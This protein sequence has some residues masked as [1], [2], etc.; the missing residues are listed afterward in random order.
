M[1]RSKSK[2]E[3]IPIFQYGKDV[4]K[5]L[6]RSPFLNAEEEKILI[7]KA[8]AK[9]KVARDRIIES[10]LLSVIGVAKRYRRPGIDLADLIQE[11]NIGLMIA[12]DRF[13]LSRGFRFSTYALWW[14]RAMIRRFLADHGHT[15]REPVHRQ[16]LKTKLD[17]FKYSYQRTHGYLPT[18]EELAFEAGISLR[19]LHNFY[20]NGIFYCYSLTREFCQ[21][22]EQ[23]YME[24]ELEDPSQSIEF[25]LKI[26]ELSA[27]IEDALVTLREMC[28]KSG[29]SAAVRNLKIFL[30]RLFNEDSTLKSIGDEHG[31]SR[32]RVRQ[33]CAGN[34]ETLRKILREQGIDAD[35]LTHS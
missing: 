27:A 26:I 9:D 6:K 8:Q 15:I 17:N 2:P 34:S 25:E 19:R 13:D 11:G 16:D 18:D 23:Y 33:L 10:H 7:K 29:N 20:R 1:K 22:E 35:F 14:V 12:I 21:D 5:A 4:Q 32:E 3:S 24:F 30:E 28:Q 31:I